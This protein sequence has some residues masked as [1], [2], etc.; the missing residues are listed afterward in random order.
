VNISTVLAFVNNDTAVRKSPAESAIVIKRPAELE[1]LLRTITGT[2][3]TIVASHVVSAR[4]TTYIA[5]PRSRICC[6]AAGVCPRFMQ[7]LGLIC[8]YCELQTE[9][10]VC[11]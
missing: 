9:L 6:S 4:Q 7:E 5:G 1:M 8:D 2:I 11:F 10:L 3:K